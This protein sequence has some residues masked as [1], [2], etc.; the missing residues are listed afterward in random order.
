[1][2]TRQKRQARNLLFILKEDLSYLVG[3]VESGTTTGKELIL[4]NTYSAA[5]KLY[6]EHQ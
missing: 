4:L 5:S 6:A 3:S 2:E 1:M